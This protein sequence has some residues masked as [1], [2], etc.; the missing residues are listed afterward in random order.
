MA[1]MVLDSC[2]DCWDTRILTSVSQTEASKGAERQCV[3]SCSRVPEAVHHHT[4]VLE[5]V[6]DWR[7]QVVSK[8]KE[9]T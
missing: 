6:K 7:Q 8:C 1:V 4:A 5:A 2:I 3:A 9:Y